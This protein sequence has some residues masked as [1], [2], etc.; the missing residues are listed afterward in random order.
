[1]IRLFP[2]IVNFISETIYPAYGNHFGKTYL[3]L[4]IYLHFVKIKY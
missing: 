3:S 1:M 2:S 4:I